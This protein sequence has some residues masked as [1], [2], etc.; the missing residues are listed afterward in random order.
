M[1]DSTN[2]DSIPADAPAVM[3]PMDGRYEPAW[4]SALPRFAKAA[5]IAYSNLGDRSAPVFDLEAGEASP[6]SVATSCALRLGLGLWSVIYLPESYLAA[7]VAALRSK[8]LNFTPASSWPQPGVY[9]H[10]ADPTGVPHLNV[11]WAPVQPLAVQDRWTAGYDISSTYGTY[12]SLTPPPIPE[13]E[14]MAAYPPGLFVITDLDNMVCFHDGLMSYRWVTDPADMG[15]L[16]AWLQ[17][18]DLDAK[19]YPVT[20][21]AVPN[22]YGVQR[23]PKPPVASTVDPTP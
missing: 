22:L 2:P 6:D 1:Y 18:H 15:I 5:Q 4:A 8:S 9:L 3:W 21:A 10:A 12:P 17:G 23:F 16:I 13:D 19:V 11:D 20:S 14:D 7:A